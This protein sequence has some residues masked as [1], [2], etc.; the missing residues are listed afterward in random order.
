VHCVLLCPKHSKTTKADDVK[1][2][3]VFNIT[4]NYT[5]KNSHR[6]ATVVKLIVHY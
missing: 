4:I 3:Y 2:K 5:D 1:N 6:K